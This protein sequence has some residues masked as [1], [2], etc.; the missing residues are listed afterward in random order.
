MVDILVGQC[1]HLPTSQAP[2]CRLPGQGDDKCLYCLQRSSSGILLPAAK[3]IP[4]Q[5]TGEREDV[6]MI[7]RNLCRNPLLRESEPIA[8]V[9]KE[10]SDHLRSESRTSDYLT[11][12][13]LHWL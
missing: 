12:Q 1:G 5:K 9:E 11:L 3:I 2:A 6:A 8:V 4:I 13:V 7:Q 10:A